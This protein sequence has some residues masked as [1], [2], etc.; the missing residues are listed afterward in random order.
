MR[1]PSILAIIA[2]TFMLILLMTGCSSGDYNPPIIPE[3]INGDAQADI[4]TAVEN[5]PSNHLLWGLWQFTA[6]PAAGTLDVAR[7]RGASMHLNAVPFLEGPPLVNLSIESDIVFNGNMLDV[8]IGLRHPFLGLNEFTG[9]DVRGI[10]ISNGNLTGFDDPALRL[11]LTGSTRLRNADGYTRWWNPNEFPYDSTAAIFGYKDGLLGAPDSDADFNCTLN[12]YKYF[13]DDL[14][15]NDGLDELNPAHRGYFKAGSKNVR[16]YAMQLGTEGLVF[17][18]AV[19]AS[20]EFPVDPP[21]YSNVP[22]A[23]ALEAN[24]PESHRITVEEQFNDMWS[25]GTDFNGGLRLDTTVYSFRETARR[26]D[27][28]LQWPG[29]VFKVGTLPAVGEGYS[30]L[31]QAAVLP[32]AI[33]VNQMPL[34]ISVESPESG[35]GSLLP[36]EPV[37][38]Y[39][40]Y[41]ADVGEEPP[42][43]PPVALAEAVTSTSIIQGQSVEFDA[44]ASHDPDGTIVGYAWESDGDGQY[45]DS[46]GVNPTIPF[47]TVGTFYVDVRVTDNDAA[48]D[49]LDTTIQVNVA[50]PNQPPVAQAQATTATTI[51]EG[52][53]VSFNGSASYDPDGTI[54]TYA[55]ERGDDTD[56]ND[57]FGVTP[58]ISFPS[59]G[60]FYVDLR[61]TDDDGA[62]DTLN[63]KIHV[64]VL[65]EP[66]NWFPDD[67]GTPPF[68]PFLYTISYCSSLY[69][70][71]ALRYDPP[72]GG[73]Y[74]DTGDYWYF[75][76]S[77]TYGAVSDPD[78][79]FTG[80]QFNCI[81]TD[82]L[83]VPNISGTVI[84]ELRQYIDLC[85]DDLLGGEYMDGSQVRITLNTS[86]SIWDTPSE[87]LGNTTLLYPMS[88]P[89]YGVIGSAYVNNHL[90]GLQGFRGPLHSWYTSTFNLTSYK[91]QQVRIGYVFSSGFYALMGGCNWNGSMDYR[92]GIRLGSWE[93]KAL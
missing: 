1:F 57:A 20:W 22:E 42:N 88:G 4:P 66:F 93:V 3:T 73:T 30:V 90:N 72:G 34:L 60:D 69:E 41:F 29:Y 47:P 18:Y 62:N 81:V 16:H 2:I 7:L 25:N 44:S 32:E 82:A 63:T 65:E 12:G 43:Q 53:T 15:I 14:G 31:Y 55:W 28:Y 79:I 76:E 58:T 19:D 67:P 27:V 89:S 26:H 71:W 35:Y 59:P 85:Y 84:L 50:P 52:E 80:H 48:T 68:T 91:G 86:S 24:A 36:G 8:D 83:T 51:L 6:D 75:E 46:S 70:N 74:A 38:S 64:E 17:N 5:A 77:G 13:S 23:F 21:P 9:F 11:A 33:P 37:T 10:L 40:V 54:V 56:Y 39:F 49:V 45:D 87:V 78:E 92:Y 61:V